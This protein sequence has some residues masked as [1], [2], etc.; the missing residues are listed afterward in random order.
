MATPCILYLFAK[1]KVLDVIH[2]GRDYARS[3]GI[4]VDQEYLKFFVMISILTAIS[5]SLVGPVSFFRLFRCKCL[6]SFIFYL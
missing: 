4:E 2:L 1:S 6:L 5:T 3:L